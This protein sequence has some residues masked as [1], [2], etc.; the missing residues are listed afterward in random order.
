M[1]RGKL[2]LNIYIFKTF[3]NSSSEEEII[4]YRYKLSIYSA[5]RREEL[6]NRL[7]TAA[8]NTIRISIAITIS[9]AIL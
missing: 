2:G 5:Y 8:I 3:K 9:T 7:S 6:I 4:I 1:L